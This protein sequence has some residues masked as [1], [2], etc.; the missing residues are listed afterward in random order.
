MSEPFPTIR[1]HC[2]WKG[3]HV[4]FWPRHSF[5][6]EQDM[7]DH[8]FRRFHRVGSLVKFEDRKDMLKIIPEDTNAFYSRIVDAD[9]IIT[10]Q[11]DSTA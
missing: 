1:A 6:S 5:V 10:Y 3:T 11:H 7:I 9:E 4:E 2:L 8:S